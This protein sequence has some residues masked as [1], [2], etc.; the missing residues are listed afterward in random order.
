MKQMKISTIDERIAESGIEYLTDAEA[1]SVLTGIPLIILKDMVNAYGFHGLIK[2]VDMIDLSNEERIK[3]DLAYNITQRISKAQICKGIIVRNPD[4]IAQL[5]V[6]ELQFSQVELVMIALLNSRNEVIKMEKVSIGTINNAIVY[7]RDILRR[8]L[9]YNA[10]AVIIAHN[11]PSGSDSP[12]SE[13]IKMTKALSEALS[14]IEVSLLDH[15]LVA[16]NTYISFKRNG[17]Y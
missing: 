10:T 5:F 6:S 15:I 9:L 4:D 12:S 8:A 14:T 3:I 1:L 11:H 16:N 13:D 17:V 2:H 7:Q